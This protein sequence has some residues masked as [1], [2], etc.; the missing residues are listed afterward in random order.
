MNDIEPIVPS[1]TDTTD[2]PPT[3]TEGDV[4]KVVITV[5]A[6]LRRAVVA[7]VE[8]VRSIFTGEIILNPS[9]S[10]GYD[11]LFYLALLFLASIIALFSSLHMQIRENRTVEQVRLLEERALR[12]EE[13]RLGATTHSAI[14]RA[15]KERNIPLEDTLE[16]VTIIKEEKKR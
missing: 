8:F 5:P 9:I 11:Y 4:D 3:P 13:Q 14:V 7:T 16:P 10:K 6:K 12:S 1:T 15:L 2:T